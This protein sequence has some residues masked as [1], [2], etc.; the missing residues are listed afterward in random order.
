M[1]KVVDWNDEKWLAFDRKRHEWMR[2]FAF[3]CTDEVH[4][5]KPEVSIEHQ[6]GNS[7][8][9]WRF[10]NNENVCEA[11]DY[12]GTDLYGGIREQ[13]LACKF[14]YNLSQNQPF[15]YMTSR[16]YPK[17]SDHTTTKS[18]DHL[19]Q[20]VAMTYLH[21]GASLLIDAADPVGTTDERF[22]EL[23]GEIYGETKAYESYL[24]KGTLAYDVS[25]YFNLDGKY[26]P[27]GNGV[28]VMDH[29]LDRDTGDAAKVP[30]F[31]ALKGASDILA[32][33]HVPYGVVNSWK[34]EKFLNSKVL[35]LPDVPGITQ[36]EAELILDYVKNGGGLYISG[37]CNSWL[38][39]EIFHTETDGYIDSTVTYMAPTDA[40][41]L[42]AEYYT[43]K[44][45]LCMFEKAMKVKEGYDGTVLAT[46]TL[47]YTKPGIYWSMFPTDIHE[48]E[49]LSQ[50]DPAFKFATIHANPPGDGSNMP[51]MLYKEIG[52]GKVVWTSMPLE[53]ADRYQHGDIF[54][55]ILKML[56]GEEFTFYADASESVECVM[57]DAPESNEK[58]L[59][60]IETRENFRIPDTYDTTVYV[61][62][63]HA[64]EKVLLLPDEK[65][66]PFT[67]ENGYVAVKLDKFSVYAMVLL[68]M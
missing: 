7:L 49:Y 48:E 31:D 9:F 45:P 64:P 61:K 21:H 44:Y 2:E 20:C 54:V 27:N 29:R 34:R 63:D 42:M 66:L 41:D 58:L 36:S 12:I 19:R 5:Y 30:H 10:G 17:L 68:K 1:P 53:R 18:K 43:E 3:L 39:N 35:V 60:V 51:A 33:H 62:A 14:W 13:S 56:A 37:Q 55:N 16:C 67:Y 6:Y 11:S 50:D 65:E 24:Q 22:Y 38:M 4:K 26:N 23:M 57:F 52:K 8:S 25:L 28:H 15:Q 47:P 59:G 32:S 40:S 46:I